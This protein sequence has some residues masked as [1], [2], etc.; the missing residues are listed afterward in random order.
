MKR[1]IV[2]LIL[3]AST[4]WAQGLDTVWVVHSIGPD[5]LGDFPI[6]LAIDPAG[7]IIVTGVL[8]TATTMEDIVTMK[9][10]SS[11][12]R[13]WTAHYDGPVHKSDRPTHLAVDQYGYVYVAG[14][15][16][17]MMG[18][19]ESNDGLV[20]KYHPTGEIAWTRRYEG[21]SASQDA[22]N[23]LAIDRDR[24]VLVAIRRIEDASLT[25]N[26]LVTLKFYP[27]GDAAW[28]RILPVHR[29]SECYGIGIDSQRSAVL[30]GWLWQGTGNSDFE[31][32]ALVK[33]AEDG[34]LLWF[35]PHRD[36]SAWSAN[37]EVFTM[38]DRGNCFA[39]GEI[40]KITGE[41]V[42]ATGKYNADGA[43]VW[44]REFLLEEYSDPKVIDIAT[45]HDGNVLWLATA[46]SDSTDDDMIIAKYMGNGDSAW[47]RVFSDEND[48]TPVALAVDD[49]GNLYTLCDSEI[50]GGIWGML[51]VK[52]DGAGATKWTTLWDGGGT[53]YQPCDI[54]VDL[55]KNVV[56]IGSA[57]F[58]GN[59]SSITT[60]KFRQLTATSADPPP[61]GTVVGRFALHQN[62]PNPFNPSTTITYSVAERG[63]V[64]LIVYDVLGRQVGQLVNGEVGAG[65]HSVS[66]DA[67]QMA[68]GVY[69]YQLR[70]NQGSLA[71][72]MVHLR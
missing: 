40:E 44:Q 51:L 7:D 1:T 8:R 23:G 29:W 28:A 37:A 68:S 72:T 36:S 43:L 49:E 58:P 4:V 45:D 71:K 60:I 17:G 54:A 46:R 41:E 67:S 65:T 70:S 22:M 34:S 27:T 6:A 13:L 15:S 25:M 57:D 26:E 35:S 69:M 39:A 30:G 10:S 12:T 62:F 59:A 31:F 20:L 53:Y 11:G 21:E 61:Q 33:Y 64:T 32:F 5:S 66:W 18:L 38:D 47:V 52:L 56:V 3:A 63:P 50:A 14:T 19:I 42:F 48:Q 9:F 24:N 16:R 2:F 55:D